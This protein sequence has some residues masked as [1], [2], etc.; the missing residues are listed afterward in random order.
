MTDAWDRLP[1][2]C[3]YQ[4][5]PRR[6]PV[7]A[8][9]ADHAALT[10][11][12]HVLVVDDDARIRRGLREMIEASDDVRVVGEAASGTL[13]LALDRRLRPDVAVVDVLPQAA[14]G[15]S[16]LAELASRGRPIVAI[17]MCDS[18][19]SDAI[20]AGADRFIAKGSSLIEG[21]L[22]AIRAVVHRTSPPAERPG[23]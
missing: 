20:A 6:P 1:V 13:A 12:L 16:V 22:P 7:P 14:D 17:S 8:T 3:F 4:A 18:L 19:G 11:R 2:L 10:P 15:L 5:R 21:L 9:D 23:S